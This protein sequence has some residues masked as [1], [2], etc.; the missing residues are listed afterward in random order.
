[1]K[2]DCAFNKEVTSAAT[3]LR[4]S[5]FDQYETKNVYCGHGPSLVLKSGGG[6]VLCDRLYRTCS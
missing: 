2:Y 3:A 6:Q 1:M 4:F 5:H